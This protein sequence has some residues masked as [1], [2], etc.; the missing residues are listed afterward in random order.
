[1]GDFPVKI[2]YKEGNELVEVRIMLINHTMPY[3]SFL[4]ELEEIFLFRGREFKLLLTD[5]EGDLITISNECDFA[6]ILQRLPSHLMGSIPKFT[7]QFKKECNNSQNQQATA[8]HVNV[9]CDG[10]GASSISGFRYKCMECYDFDLCSHCEHA[11]IH[12]NHL[13]VRIPKPMKFSKH[14]K[15][16]LDYAK[17]CSRKLTYEN[18]DKNEHSHKRE[19]HHTFHRKGSCKTDKRNCGADTS[20]V[21]LLKDYLQ[22]FLNSIGVDLQINGLYDNEGNL[23]QSA[24]NTD[25]ADP[26]TKNENQATSNSSDK[27]KSDKEEKVNK[28]DTALAPD[29]SAEFPNDVPTPPDTSEEWTII[30]DNSFSNSAPTPQ[31]NGNSDVANQPENTPSAPG[32]DVVN[33]DA[34]N[35]VGEMYHS[36]P[37][38]ISAL[39]TLMSMGVATEPRVLVHLLEINNA[40]IGK[41]LDI[42][43]P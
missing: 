13:M 22:P 21:Y 1:M 32:V 39:E 2:Y 17:H 19:S 9:V 26:V 25:Q 40:D 27:K 35:G 33:Q 15:Y 12:T 6:N 29:S 5:K 8:T 7:L 16:L 41:V 38:I 43:L 34:R 14:F 31:A 36:N 20:G 10:C 24:Q 4:K 30:K 18:D 3:L 37:K 11:G 28:N 23:Y 42:V